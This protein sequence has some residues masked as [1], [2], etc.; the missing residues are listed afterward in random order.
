VL[1]KSLYFSPSLRQKKT[2][3]ATL[4]LLS[5][6]C[7]IPFILVTRQQ[8]ANLNEVQIESIAKPLKQFDETNERKRSQND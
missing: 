5:E 1:S 7:T 3:K 4:K 8:P 6:D 2:L